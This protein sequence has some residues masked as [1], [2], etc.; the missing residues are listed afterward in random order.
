MEIAGA[1]PIQHHQELILLY[2]QTRQ[3][4]RVLCHVLQNRSANSVQKGRHL[5]EVL[6]VTSVESVG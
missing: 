4:Q 3:N 5:G 2:A 1:Y 6:T